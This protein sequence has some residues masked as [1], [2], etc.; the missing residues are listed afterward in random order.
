MISIMDG[1]SSEDDYDNYRFNIVLRRVYGG[2][3]L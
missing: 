1:D 2:L 3:R